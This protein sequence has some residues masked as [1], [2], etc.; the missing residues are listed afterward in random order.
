[1]YKFVG[2]IYEI[3]IGIKIFETLNER[4]WKLVE[5]SPPQLRVCR[6]NKFSTTFVFIMKIPSIMMHN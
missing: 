4:N 6:S 5:H 2:E 3:R 1:M